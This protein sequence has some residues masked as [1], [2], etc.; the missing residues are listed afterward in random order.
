M[1][2]LSTPNNGISFLVIAAIVIAVMAA[3]SVGM[4]RH[5]SARYLRLVSNEEI[6]G[7]F[8]SGDRESVRKVSEKYGLEYQRVVNGAVEEESRRGLPRYQV[9]HVTSPEETSI[10]PE[11]RSEALRRLRPY[12]VS[13]EK[14]LYVA[15]PLFLNSAGSGGMG[16]VVY[17][18]L[19]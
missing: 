1:I 11:E 16:Y 10:L 18:P 15:F 14:G 2:K 9:V 4:S 5:A 19:I 12:I 8:L 17:S 13:V 6:T 7:A 3:T